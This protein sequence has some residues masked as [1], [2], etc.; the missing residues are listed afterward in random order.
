MYKQN[1]RTIGTKIIR[2]CVE[3]GLKHERSFWACPKVG[4][5]LLKSRATIIG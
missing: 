5:F 1:S 4:R 3:N 2:L